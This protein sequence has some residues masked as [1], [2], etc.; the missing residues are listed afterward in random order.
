MD[1]LQENEH[2]QEE[3]QKLAAKV[4]QYILQVK[5]PSNYWV[6]FSLFLTIY[7]R[8]F[9]RYST[10]HIKYY[11]GATFWKS[12][13]LSALS[14]QGQCHKT[15]IF[16]K[17]VKLNQYIS[18]MIADGLTIFRFLLNNFCFESRI[19]SEIYFCV[20]GRLSRVSA[21]SSLNSGKI[22][23]NVRVHVIDGFWNNF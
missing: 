6:V 4:I 7:L 22:R 15:S 8:T 14:L 17:P 3:L 12:N 5:I 9:A 10:N 16:G 18:S 21:P 1:L 11:A 23:Q 19:C 20:I 13:L 2:L